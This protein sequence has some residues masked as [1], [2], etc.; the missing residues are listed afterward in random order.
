MTPQQMQ[1]LYSQMAQRA[2][3][4]QMARMQPPAAQAAPQV[5]APQQAAVPWQQ[6]YLQQRQQNHGIGL[7]TRGLPNPQEGFERIIA[8]RN[9]EM[10]WMFGEA[11]ARRDD[12]LT[13]YKNENWKSDPYIVEWMAKNPD[14]H[15]VDWNDALTNKV[16]LTGNPHK[17]YFVNVPRPWEPGSFFVGTSGRN[18]AQVQDLLGRNSW[19]SP[20]RKKV[21][22]RAGD[23][24]QS[25]AFR[26]AY[27]K[28][29][30]KR[31]LRNIRSPAHY[32]GVPAARQVAGWAESKRDHQ[33]HSAGY[34]YDEAAF[35]ALPK[36]EQ[37]KLLNPPP[38]T[39][40]PEEFE[41]IKNMT[42][43]A[44]EQSDPW[45]AKGINWDTWGKPTKEELA[46]L[47][48]ASAY[49][50]FSHGG[51]LVGRPDRGLGGG[52][53]FIPVSGPTQDWNGP[54]GLSRNFWQWGQ[55]EDGKDEI[56][57][58][59]EFAPKELRYSYERVRPDNWEAILKKNAPA[60]DRS[61]MTPADLAAEGSYAA[62][63]TQRNATPYTT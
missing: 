53:Q 27:N 16:A 29:Y 48:K 32:G 34:G 39:T 13:K 18:W 24:G 20:F 51:P 10:A 3:A 11:G 8:D 4:P 55:G 35:Y 40:T 23:V 54:Q 6:Q 36:A 61:W 62:A 43:K 7:G 28:E 45:R 12:M 9:D 50:V 25:D 57:W 33:V 41:S 59:P 14:F 26:D 37:E 17:T 5:P 44:M 1:M 49:H 42:R 22:A 30:N 19:S 38:P 58:N 56:W 46:D 47:G 2:I 21:A 31:Q 63:M 15:V 52:P 60:V